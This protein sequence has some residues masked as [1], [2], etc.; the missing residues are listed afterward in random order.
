MAHKNEL[1]PNRFYIGVADLVRKH[2]DPDFIPE[3]GVFRRGDFVEDQPSNLEVIYTSSAEF[4]E[5]VYIWKVVN[6]VTVDESVKLQSPNDILDD[7]LVI[8]FK[9]ARFI[10]FTNDAHPYRITLFSPI[11]RDKVQVVDSVES[12]GF[13]PKTNY[14][15][16]PILDAIDDIMRTYSQG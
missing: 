8:P 5:Y 16:M 4:G 6:G 12:V 9:E 3:P 7:S 11:V 2:F 15:R 10:A 14:E 13:E 1:T